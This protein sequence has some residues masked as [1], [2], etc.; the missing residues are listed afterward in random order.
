VRVLRAPFS[1]NDRARAERSTEGEVKIV[2]TRK[3][4]ILG[5]AIVG[6][7]AGELIAIWTLAV[8]KQMDIAEFRDLVVAYPTFSE[9]WKRAA[10]SFYAAETR[11]PAV[12]RLLRFLRMFG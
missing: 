2:T 6:P 11:R 4:R 12:G 10:V 5:A 9:T 1:E 8:K 3:G 7:H